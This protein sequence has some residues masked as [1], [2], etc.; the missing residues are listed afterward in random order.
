MQVETGCRATD[1]A[2]KFKKSLR[3]AGSPR[4][5]RRSTQLVEQ[6]TENPRVGGSIL[7]LARL[8]APDQSQ[9]V[10][11][12]NRG[13]KACHS[14]LQLKNSTTSFKVPKDSISS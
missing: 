4:M 1:L 2:P 12:K 5:V 8:F 3:E 10:C 11:T 7:S 6:R 13:E 14:H 9:K